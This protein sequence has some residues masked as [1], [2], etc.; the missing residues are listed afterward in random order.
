VSFLG[1]ALVSGRCRDVGGDARRPRRHEQLRSAADL[2]GEPHG[3]G[4]G[5]RSIPN[6][7]DKSSSGQHRRSSEVCPL[8]ISCGYL[9]LSMAQLAAAQ[10]LA[11][12][13]RARR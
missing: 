8:E 5:I 10:A 9:F 1:P 3:S 4:C 13:C 6:M 12:A 7:I 11:F 2:P